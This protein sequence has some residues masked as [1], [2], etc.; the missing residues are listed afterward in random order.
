[1]NGMRDMKLFEAIK[2]FD[3]AR[4]GEVSSATREWFFAY[5]EENNHY[6]GRLWELFRFV[7]D[8]DISTITI[9]D[10]RA[11]TSSL[12]DKDTRFTDHPYREQ[13]AGGLSQDSYRNFIRSARQFFKWLVD[14]GH[15]TNSPAERLS[16]PPPSHD[17]PKAIAIDDAMSVL[18]AAHWF[19]LRDE[20]YYRIL[21]CGAKHSELDR[22]VLDNLKLDHNQAVIHRRRG[23]NSYRPIT[24]ALDRLTVDVLRR[25]LS[26]RSNLVST[27]TSDSQLLFTGRQEDFRYCVRG[28]IVLGLRNEA[29]IHVLASSAARA[30]G[31]ASILRSS[32]NLQRRTAKVIEKGRNG[33]QIP[34][35][36]HLD[37]DACDTVADWLAVA[38]PGE[39][40]FPGVHGQLTTSG[41]YQIVT[42]LATA[43]QVSENAN[44]HAWRHAW[45]LE[46]LRAG[47]DFVTVAKVL[48]NK[49]ETVMLN[50]ARWTDRDIRERYDQFNWKNKNGHSRE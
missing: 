32:V 48:G 42:G 14:E 10:L 23:T 38:P 3:R 34:R 31:V 20:S 2:L 29:L 49:P 16:V 41:V 50:Y 19:R 15:L 28:N 5:N 37:Q 1:M 24:L 27:S 43:A 47:A 22:L 7:G 9:D 21:L 4:M 18:T 33:F 44:P 8:V 39:Y 36:I 40:L 6:G 45:S 17:E 12:R 35:I 13:Q 26:V 25:W 11:W 30:G 46:A